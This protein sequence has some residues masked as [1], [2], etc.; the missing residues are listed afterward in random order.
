MSDLKNCNDWGKQAASGLSCGRFEMFAI[1]EEEHSAHNIFLDV[2][3]SVQ[4]KRLIAQKGAFFCYDYLNDLTQ[5]SVS[6]IP[7][8]IMD[9]KFDSHSGQNKID[10]IL[11]RIHE[12][13]VKDKQTA[14]AIRH[15]E[16]VLNSMRDDKA[17]SE[18]EIYEE[19]FKDIDVKLSQYYY[20]RKNLFPDLDRYIEY[21][22][23]NYSISIQNNMVDETD[24]VID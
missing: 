7:R 19:M 16:D 9:W 21:V 24:N 4:N 3:K 23:N 22:N 2:V 6:K 15:V 8:I 18:S 13:D 12:N 1:N 20:F 10:D 11:S 5:E 14:A 17:P